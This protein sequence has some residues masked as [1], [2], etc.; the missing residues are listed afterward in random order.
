MSDVCLILEG[1]YPY[2]TGGVSSCV[3]QLIEET[4]HLTYTIVYIGPKKDPNQEYKYPVPGNVRLIKELYLFDSFSENSTEPHEIGLTQEQI[5]ILEKSLLFKREESIHQLYTTFFDPNTR[6]CDP[7]KLFFSKESWDIVEKEYKNT[8]KNN[9]SPSFIDFFYTW[10]FTNFPIF[11][12]LSMDL[13]KANIYHTMC[14]GY[15]G[16]LG[17]VAKEKY[18]KP[19]LLTEH[20][21]YTHERK[22]E[23]SQSQWLYSNNKEIKAKKK[24]SYFKDWWYQKFKVLGEL[25]YNHS[26]KITTLYN[27]NKQKQIQLG[28]EEK[29]IEII[30]NGINYKKLQYEEDDPNR[31]LYKKPDDTFIIGLVG[32]VVPIKDI[33][34][35]IKS[36]A[37]ISKKIPNIEVLIMGPTDEDEEYFEECKTLIK[38]L[39]LK[40]FIKF[41][42]KVNLKYYYEH[43]DIIVLS[44]ISEGQPLV[45]LEAFAFG[46]PAVATDVGSC[47]ELI[48]GTSSEDI[49]LGS[50]GRTIPFGLSDL[51]GESIIELLENDEL[52]EQMGEVAK[53]RFLNFYQEKFTINKYLK[54]Y[55]KYLMNR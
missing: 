29:R 45:L 23:I 27:G 26:D 30:P 41:T 24:M 46:I 54:L 25:T 51:L 2:I 53:K 49:A 5:S 38:L 35:F 18:H 47:K 39:D 36:I 1:T 48:Y 21:I 55:N 14:T 31:N 9:E 13:P 11:K 17:V 7:E 40:N 10:R 20:G 19:L 52:R 3:H 6:V 8:F 22:I 50:C 43:L 32:R 37:Y 15:A 34:T 33:K 4:P 28:A 42:G 44:S 12:I 16:L